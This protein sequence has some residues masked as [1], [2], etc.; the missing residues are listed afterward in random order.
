MA[1]YAHSH[2]AQPPLIGRELETRIGEVW[3][4]V[5]VTEHNGGS[6]AV[7]P[8]TGTFP[9]GTTRKTFTFPITEL[10]SWRV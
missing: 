4:P 5:I 10:A 6:I 8:K 1:T 7:K 3:V 9:D 2:G